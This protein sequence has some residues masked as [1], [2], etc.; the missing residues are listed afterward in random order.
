[1]LESINLNNNYFLSIDDNI[2][3]NKEN[4]IDIK[5]LTISKALSKDV[6][7]LKINYKKIKKEEYKKVLKKLLVIKEKLLK[8]KKQI[9]VKTDLKILLGYII[10]YDGNIQQQNEFI[11]AINAIFYKS[12]Y[13]RYNYIYDTVCDYLDGFFYGKN[14]CDFKNNQCGEKRGT[15]SYI[16]CCHHY[17]N[18]LFGPLLSNNLIPCEHL[19]ENHTCGAK[20]IACKLFTCDYLEK[21]GV[22][23]R[24]KDILL[25]EVFFNPIQKY[26]IKCMVFTPKDI[27]IKRLMML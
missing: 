19:K 3:N 1:M 7:L 6:F 24:I 4:I 21:K 14:F 9:G 17:K 20:C 26:F 22:K 2:D 23:F 18:K 5:E 12:R 15:T 10:N 8:H 16:G 25:L 11:S 27:I 13:E